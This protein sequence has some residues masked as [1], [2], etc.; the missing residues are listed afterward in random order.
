MDEP[1]WTRKLPGISIAAL[2]LVVA[3]VGIAQARTPA[4]PN[5]TCTTTTTPPAILADGITV[6]TVNMNVNPTKLRTKGPVEVVQ[7]CNTGL[8]GFS[9]GWH[10]H[11]GPVIVNVTGGALTFYS[12]RNCTGTTVTAGHAYIES[13]GDPIIGQNLGASTATWISTQIIPVGAETAYVET[14]GFCGVS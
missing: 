12:P 6:N 11:A 14:S 2:I 5:V 4:T 3:A 10:H 8:T 9:S 1:R 7:F 13:T